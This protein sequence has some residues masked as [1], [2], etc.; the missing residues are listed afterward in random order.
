[1]G[2]DVHTAARGLGTGTAA[3]ES[4]VRTGQGG[5]AADCRR[6]RGAGCDGPAAR[7]RQITAT[8]GQE[9]RLAT[10]RRRRQYWQAAAGGR[11]HSLAGTDGQET[12]APTQGV[13]EPDF[14]PS[15]TAGIPAGSTTP[16]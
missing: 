9:D 13:I 7:A 6:R 2:P 10:T 12:L 15:G 5:R 1:M 11:L 3:T 4:D 14:L 16:H 8:S